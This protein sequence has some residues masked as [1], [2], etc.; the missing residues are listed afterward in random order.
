MRLLIGIT[1]CHKAIYP[2]ELSR[3]EPPNN[4]A[5]AGWARTTWGLD[6]VKA[7][8]DVRFFFG[9]GETRGPSFDEVFLDVDDSYNG[10]IEKVTAMCQ[11]A[12]DHGYDYLM[13]TDVDSYVH[14]QN[15]LKSEFFDWDYAGRGWG[16]GYLL[17]R[18]AMKVIAEAKQRRSWAEDS[19]VLRTL[20]AWGEKSPDNKIKLYGDGRFIFLPNMVNG[21]AELYDKEFIVVNPMTPDRMNRLDYTKSLSSILPVQYSEADLWT[22]G[23]NRVQH[24]SVHNAFNLRGEKVPYTYDEWCKLSTYDRQPFLDWMNVVFASLETDSMDECPSFEQWMGPIEGRKELLA[25]CC[26]INEECSAKIRRASIQFKQDHFG[27]TVGPHRQD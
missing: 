25:L 14:I 26:K 10:L 17:S 5:C 6:A 27:G 11:W 24:C 8:I 4:V 16:L 15:L 2:A 23:P 13:K 12:L 9:R 3:T 19:H 22:G 18:T 21:D 7:G 20:F 1:N